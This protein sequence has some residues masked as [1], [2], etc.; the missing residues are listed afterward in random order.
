MREGPADDS[1]SPDESLS[2]EIF[3]VEHAAHEESVTS[4]RVLEY[5]EQ[6]QQE[7]SSSYF[8]I[9]PGT[10]RRIIFQPKSPLN[11]VEE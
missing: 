2:S 8:V 6:V 9:P 3:I 1:E 4:N 11:D 10:P 7:D 5:L